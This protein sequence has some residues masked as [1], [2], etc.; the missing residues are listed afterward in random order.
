MVAAPRRGAAGR[1]D[2]PPAAHP[3]RRRSRSHEGAWRCGP[4]TGGRGADATPTG[5]SDFARRS[6]AGAGAG[7]SRPQAAPSVASWTH[8]RR[9]ARRAPKPPP[10]PGARPDRDRRPPRMRTAHGPGPLEAA[11]IEVRHRRGARGATGLA[12]D[13]R[14]RLAQLY[15]RAEIVDALD[16]HCVGLRVDGEAPDPP[17]DLSIDLVRDLYGRLG[18]SLTDRRSAD[19]PQ[20]RGGLAS[21]PPPRDRGPSPTPPAATPGQ[22]P[23]RG[24]GP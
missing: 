3:W 7:G 23:C 8:P 9:D 22:A 20:R 18:L 10:R 17:V 11:G 16:H 24:P 1:R 2:R 12:G 13:H 19:S 15:S 5:W 6:A 21:D 14:E 4:A